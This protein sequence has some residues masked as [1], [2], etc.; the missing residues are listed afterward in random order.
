[1]T[2][3]SCDAATT[4]CCPECGTSVAWSRALAERRFDAG[5]SR[6]ARRGL[7]LVAIGVLVAAFVPRLSSVDAVR[8]TAWTVAQL[9]VSIGVWWTTELLPQR[10]VTGYGVA[11]WRTVAR[12]TAI[13][14][15]SIALVEGFWLVV[16]PH[17]YGDTLHVRWWG[18]RYLAASAA[19]ELAV[20]VEA[21]VS[22]AAVWT[23][24]GVAVETRRR[25][26]APLLWIAGVAVFLA[27]V[28]V[29]AYVVAAIAHRVGGMPAA[30]LVGNA[31]RFTYDLPMFGD[32]GHLV[33]LAAAALAMRARLALRD[34]S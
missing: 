4:S 1:M 24:I 5:W 22:F 9:L 8:S 29:L 11:L 26:L 7:A 13:V 28:N 34:H 27:H 17:L 30:H 21:T 32:D 19:R 3:V 23:I 33:L 31:M 2:T 20:A 14:A 18:G 16:G 15:A 12:L 10:P 25:E 6:G